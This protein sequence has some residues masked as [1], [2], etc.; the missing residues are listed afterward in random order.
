MNSW[1]YSCWGCCKK[2][3]VSS[4]KHFFYMSNGWEHFLSL[5]YFPCPFFCS[6]LLV[7]IQSHFLALF[8]TNCNGLIPNM[9]CQWIVCWH[10]WQYY[11][12]L[13]PFINFGVFI[14]WKF[15]K[16]TSN[17]EKKCQQDVWDRTRPTLY[18]IFFKCNCFFSKQHSCSAIKNY[19]Y[20]I[21]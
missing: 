13:Q 18:P 17:L 20:P 8:L 9:C 19:L 15:N 16:Q 21:C 10:I 5:H 2:N 7:L 11:H 6:C 1:S 14:L 3:L 12:L 4:S